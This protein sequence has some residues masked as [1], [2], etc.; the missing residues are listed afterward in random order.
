M[1]GIRETGTPTLLTVGAIA[2]GEGIVRTGTSLGG[3]ALVVVTSAT[4]ENSDAGAAAV[5]TSADAA[6]AD[7]KHQV[8][9][10]TPIAIGTDSVNA[11]GTAT[12]LAR[13]D[14]DHA[15]NLPVQQASATVLAQTVSTTDVLMTGMSITPGAGDYLVMFSATPSN[16]NINQSV[17]A[18]LYI[19]GVQ[20]AHTERE[21]GPTSTANETGFVGFQT[22]AVGVLD[23]QVLDVRWRVS[24]NTGS[25]LARTFTLLR[26]N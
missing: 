11:P 10:G 15:V 7:H 24:A 6:R 9:T 19:N 16:S 13:S 4:P 18:S 2:D 22:E 12:T 20:V 14:H 5:G 1:R 26:L 17:W 21:R 3:V 25:V 8:L 23:A